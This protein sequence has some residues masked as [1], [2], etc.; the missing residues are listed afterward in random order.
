MY[1][2]MKAVQCE[3]RLFHGEIILVN[4]VDFPHNSQKKPGAK[5]QVFFLALI[6]GKLSKMRLY[7]ETIL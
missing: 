2:Q 4:Y 7:Q 3:N 1:L 5:L 6:K